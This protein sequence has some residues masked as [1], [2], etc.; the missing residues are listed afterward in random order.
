[1]L[2]FSA[3][4]GLILTNGQTPNPCLAQV[5]ML[6]KQNPQFVASLKLASA[7]N[8]PFDAGKWVMC[9]NLEGAKYHLMTVQ[10]SLGSQA[11]PMEF[12]L[13]LPESC[14]AADAATLVNVATGAEAQGFCQ[15][16][17][18]ALLQPGLILKGI[19]SKSRD[20]LVPPRAGCWV[21]V[22]VVVFMTLL[23]IVSTALHVHA[24][25][26]QVA[27]TEATADLLEDGREAQRPRPGLESNII[28]SAFSLIGPNGTWDKLWQCP[29]YKDTD[30][31]NGTRALSMMWVMLGHTFIMSQGIAGYQN[32]QDI[33]VSPLNDAAAET[34]WAFMFVLNGQLSVDTFFYMGGFL[35]SLL[36]LKELEKTGKKF[37]HVQALIFRYLRLTPS[38][39]F[40]MVVYYFIWP[41][42]SSGPFSPRFQNSVYR[43][44]DISWW[45][46]LTYTVNFVPFDSDDVCMGWTWYL[47]DDMIFFVFGIIL[48]PLY[49][50]SKML[51]WATV[52]ILTLASLFVTGYLVVAHDLGPYALDYHYADYSYWAYSK[53]YTRIPAYFVGIVAAWILLA[54]EKNGITRERGWLGPIGA[55]VMWFLAI[56]L[57]TFIV[58]IPANDSGFHKNSWGKTASTLYFVLSRPVWAICWAILTFLC[59]Y[60]H[61]PITNGLL[62][63][64]FWTPFARLTY[65]AYLCHPL[66]IKL[67]AA[68]AVQYYTFSGMD[69]LYRLCG[70]AVL[71]YTA[72]FAVWCYI[73]RPMMSFTTAMLK[74]NKSN[75]A[76]PDAKL[77]E[78]A[79][80][81]KPLAGK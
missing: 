68:C 50:K 15:I 28:F 46:E 30:C 7:Q 69:L 49:H 40:V 42:L 78:E 5:M 45:S 3:I 26:R 73:E 6:A 10:A 11:L 16:L 27:A 48:V 37:M 79:Q 47:G 36:T 9:D 33:Q 63:H 12:G 2:L 74:S 72:S 13:C 1:M 56:G 25:K 66:V 61:A 43:R 38:L 35:F 62:S 34:N 64:R 39:A 31:L 65:G 19:D 60:G 14:T 53:P 52:T 23:I 29:P 80:G 44:C 51:G 24:N 55:T 58:L 67:A 8:L 32:P 21:A 81:V 17:M 71:A 77:V 75:R 20:D 54:M 41:N 18:P 57:T 22:A 70:N 59:Y 4:A 76:K